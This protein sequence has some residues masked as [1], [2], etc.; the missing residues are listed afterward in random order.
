MIWPAY[1]S[2]NLMIVCATQTP[3]HKHT[4]WAWLFIWSR[5]RSRVCS[6]SNRTIRHPTSR[7]VSK[8]DA[9]PS[10]YFMKRMLHAWCA[11]WWIHRSRNMCDIYNIHFVWIQNVQQIVVYICYGI[12]RSIGR[13]ECS[14]RQ[15]AYTFIYQANLCFVHPYCVCVELDLF[16]SCVCVVVCVC[17]CVLIVAPFVC[18]LSMNVSTCDSVG[19][20]VS[21]THDPFDR[22]I[23]CAIIR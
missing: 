20:W 13:A 5:D 12:G 10:I 23:V 18:Q 15:L 7:M 11:H 14:V 16:A 17:V 22:M 1:T 2:N 21:W 8:S 9:A 4:T 6:S 19:I 3:Q